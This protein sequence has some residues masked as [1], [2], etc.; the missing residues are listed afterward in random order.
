[1]IQH[2][3]LMKLKP[4]TSDEQIEDAFVAGRELPD[5]IP[6]LL[7]LTYGRD[8]SEPEHGFTLASVVELA[9]EDALDAYLR[10]PTRT[11]Y[12][13][14]HVDPMVD[15]R[16]ELDVPS[17]GTHLPGPSTWYWGIRSGPE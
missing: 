2:I 8:R 13:E 3:V 14:D 16:I 5:Q 15:E 1:V 10:H 12:I 9:D 4:G 11:E 6:G 17:E 7:K